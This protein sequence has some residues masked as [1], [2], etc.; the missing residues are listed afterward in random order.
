MESHKR[1]TI[2]FFSCSLNTHTHHFKQSHFEE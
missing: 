1:D 2:A